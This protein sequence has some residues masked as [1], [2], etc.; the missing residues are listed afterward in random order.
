MKTCS[1][2]ILVLI[3]ASG[4][5]TMI[6]TACK[7]DNGN[8]NPPAQ[9]P[10]LTTSS[11]SVT[12]LTAAT[13]GG[14]ITSDGGATITSRGVCWSTSLVPT[15]TDN[16]TV[17]GPG[18]GI[19]TSVL[20]GL[21]NG[22][23]YHVRAYATNSAG[24]AYGSAETFIALRLKQSYQGGYLIYILQPAD[25]GYVAGVPHGLLVSAGTAFDVKW[26]NGTYITT[27]ATAS[28]L[29]AG[30]TNTLTIV[31]VQGRGNH[32]AD[33]CF[34]ITDAGYT[35]WYLPSKDELNKIYL[36]HGFDPSR[37]YWSSTESG[38]STAWIQASDGTQSTYDKNGKF[39]II[40]VRSF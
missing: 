23:V 37:F 15:I 35:D 34:S 11:V 5:L 33:Q 40:G 18:A 31:A 32:A 28:A 12:S 38:K 36:A 8:N 19:F 7:K 30:R 3:I 26:S 25:P 20:P 16:K 10:V 27:G 2:A 22:A 9:L 24:T 17:N 14:N 1:R 6:V 4:C 29:G 21:T 13:S 39:T